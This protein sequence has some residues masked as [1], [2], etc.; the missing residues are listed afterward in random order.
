MPSALICAMSRTLDGQGGFPPAGIGREVRCSAQEIKPRGGMQ[1]TDLANGVIQRIGSGLLWMW[2]RA[3]RR[4]RA[5][6]HDE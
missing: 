5:E 6:G 4:Q 3:R 1:L 2:E